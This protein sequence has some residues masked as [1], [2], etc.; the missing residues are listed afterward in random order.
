M[1]REEGSKMGADAAVSLNKWMAVIAYDGTAYAGFQRQPNQ[2]TVQGELEGVLSRMHK[3]HVAVTGSGRTDA[4]V[5]ARGQVIHFESGLRLTDEAWLKALNAQLPSDIRVLSVRKVPPHFHARYDAKAKEY[6]YFI[7]NAPI[8]DPF[9]RRYTCHVP[10]KLDLGR[11]RQ[12][13]Q[14][15]VGTH[16]FTAF[17]SAQSQ[18]T[19][20]IRTIEQLEVKG[21][22]SVPLGQ[23]VVIR[24]RGT[25]F[26]HHMV[27][28]IAGTLIEV[29]KGKKSLS[30]VEMALKGKMRQLAGP[31]APACGLFL[32]EVFYP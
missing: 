1:V 7:M 18:V 10:I 3:E 28:M 25:G 21:D 29:G 16:D 24:C 14:L 31:V 23:L 5:H 11:M 13:A 20:K 27:R 32:W 2:P 19:N 12:A 17:S 9:Y 22:P 15:F 4:G 6:R 8:Q 26:L 30:D